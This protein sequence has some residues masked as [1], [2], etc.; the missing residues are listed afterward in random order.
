M[1]LQLQHLSY[2]RLGEIAEEFLKRYHPKLILP[3]PIENIAEQKL[4]LKI[5]Q[6]M[7]LKKSYDVDG[8]L[9]SD[10]TTIFV[11]F[12]L[13][14]KQESRTRFTIAHEVGHWV[15]HGKLFRDLEINSAG[16]LGNLIEKVTDAENQWLEYQAYSF[17][18][19]VLVPRDLL[20]NEIKKRVGRVPQLETPEILVPI[21]Q[22]L[23][24]VFKVSGLVM[25]RRLEKE[26]IVKLNS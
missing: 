26:K 10:L 22:D 1:S 7:N 24:D 3:I 5:I 6:E 4:N 17:A 19:Q 20:F 18:G 21:A 8:F 16:D 11:D 15:L 12:D 23:L 13:Y 9:T 25:S 14:L 2:Q